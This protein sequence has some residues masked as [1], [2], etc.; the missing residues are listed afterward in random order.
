MKTGL[1][2]LNN[3][4][5]EPKGRGNNNNNQN[6]FGNNNYRNNPDDLFDL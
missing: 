6:R 1:V 3:L 4:F 5:E 2:N